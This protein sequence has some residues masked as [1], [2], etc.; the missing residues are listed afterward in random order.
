M[1]KLAC[2]P[3][4]VAVLV[5]VAAI[6]YAV[7]LTRIGMDIDPIDT[8]KLPNR[9]YNV[10][11]KLGTDTYLLGGGRSTGPQPWEVAPGVSFYGSTEGENTYNLDGVSLSDIGEGTVSTFATNDF[12]EE[13]GIKTGGYEAET[14]GVVGAILDYNNGGTG[15]YRFIKSGGNEFN[16]TVRFS[17][18][19]ES[20]NDLTYNQ[21]GTLW[22][23]GTVFDPEP[24]PVL[25]YFDDSG[26]FI[27]VDN[28]LEALGGFFQ[29][30]EFMGIGVAYGYTAPDRDPAQPL[31][32]CSYDS[33]LTWEAPSDLPW[34]FGTINTARF[35]DPLVGW[36][37]GETPDGAAFA[38]T[39]D[40]GNTW[41]KQTM[42]DATYIWDIE[43]ALVDPSVCRDGKSWVLGAALGTYYADDYMKE[44]IVYRTLDGSTW[45]ELWRVPGYGGDIYFDHRG[46]GEI[47]IVQ[48]GL[49]GDAMFSRYA[50]HDF[51]GIE[52]LICSM[53]IIYPAAETAHVDEPFT[54]RL[55]VYGPWGRPITVDTVVWSTDV[56][57]LF[58]DPDDPTIATLTAFEPYVDVTVTCSLPEFDLETSQ[59]IHVEP[60]SE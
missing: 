56:G 49:D 9:T 51:F 55:G 24:V 45:E 32:T 7:T 34:V 20:L 23:A 28:P 21:D 5:L 37:A 58:I 59:V 25:G 16:R 31:L 22:G 57:S 27:P 10:I 47:A 30:V 43:I 44:S 3:W 17:H 19:D 13:V 8:E 52:N 39:K 60:Y 14:G 33:G 48:N 2:V 4:F 41:M 12:I 38:Y 53:E 54:M 11:A 29:G 15:L 46:D 36:V 18:A 1:K 50:A 26:T 35:I 6:A 40:G 42:P